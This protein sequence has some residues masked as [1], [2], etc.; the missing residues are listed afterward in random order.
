MFAPF[1]KL[2]SGVVLSAAL[3]GLAGYAFA[4]DPAGTILQARGTVR[5]QTDDDTRDLSDGNAVFLSDLV[6]TAEASRADMR[7]GRD[8]LIQIGADTRI[9]IADFGAALGAVL[10]LDQGAVLIDKAPDS[11]ALPLTVQS[12]Y[13]Q[14]AVRG[15]R[16]FVGPSRNAFAVFVDRG[17]VEV[18]GGGASVMLEAGQ[19]TSIATVGDVPLPPSVWSPERAAEALAQF[20]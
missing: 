10:R 5:A 7:L 2:F 11:A 17:V 12:S 1:P 4:Q 19:G 16:F 18:S 9:A 13:G 14:V 3:A 20:D 8:I 6:T 15:T